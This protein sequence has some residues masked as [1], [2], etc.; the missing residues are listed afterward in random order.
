MY[1]YMFVYTHTHTHTLSLSL[2]LSLTHT[3]TR[4]GV[5]KMLRQGHAATPQP[6]SAV[7]RRQVERRRKLV[8]RSKDR[9][10]A[11]RGGVSTE[12][13]RER[14]RERENTLTHTH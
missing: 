14:E 4:T 10:D 5:P 2:S 12:R 8:L 9:F 6:T 3:H 7:F 13:E 11:R 1:I